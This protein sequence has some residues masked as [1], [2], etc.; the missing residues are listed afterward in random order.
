MAE[1]TNM[2]RVQFPLQTIEDQISMFSRD[3]PYRILEWL[4]GEGEIDWLYRD[5]MVIN[6]VLDLAQSQVIEHS[7]PVYQ[8]IEASRLQI[9]TRVKTEVNDSA[10]TIVLLDNRLV[11][12]GMHL[13]SH[14]TGEWMT[15]TAATDDNVTVTRGEFGTTAQTLPADTALIAQTQQMSEMDEPKRGVSALPGERQ[16]NFVSAYGTRFAVTHMQDN[17]LVR[18]GW[19]QLPRITTEQWQR[20]RRAA[21]FNALFSPRYTGYVSAERGQIYVGGGVTHFI[22][23]N[24]FPLPSESSVLSWETF[25]DAISPS[26]DPHASSGEKLL[27]AGPLLFRSMERTARD[28][29]KMLEGP[30]W[31]PTL[32]A[33]A[34]TVQVDGGTVNVVKAKDDLSEL[35]D[36]QLGDWGIGLD[37]GN[38][39][40]G[41]LKG[42]NWQIRSE[43]NSKLSGIT[44]REDAI[45]GS[46]SVVLKHEK[47]HF[48]LKGAPGRNVQRFTLG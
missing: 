26:F 25:N 7:N 43:V 6:K 18:D 41:S 27:L 42:F 13:F 45:V 23:S 33:D 12:P 16:Y 10:D 11:A 9:A 34:F 1:N 4:P 3:N 17:S 47:T 20:V 8:W 5:D 2:T 30:Y 44:V 39:Y 35:P 38:F 32:F 46:Q 40:A 37:L 22:K 21:G 19:G 48:M 24:L 14:E 15:I 36:Y 29:G 28:A 31:S